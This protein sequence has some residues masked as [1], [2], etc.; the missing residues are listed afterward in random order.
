MLEIRRIQVYKQEKLYFVT[1]L[2]AILVIIKQSNSTYVELTFLM[3]FVADGMY[4]SVPKSRTIR[5]RGF[6]INIDLSLVQSSSICREDVYDMGVFLMK[7]FY[8]RLSQKNAKRLLEACYLRSTTALSA[9]KAGKQNKRA[10]C[11]GSCSSP[12]WQ[13]PGNHFFT[14]TGLIAGLTYKQMSHFA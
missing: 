8:Y 10:V 14:V 11:K 2:L 13:V 12:S 7:T 5:K 4:L 3:L 1:L 9:C 6:Q